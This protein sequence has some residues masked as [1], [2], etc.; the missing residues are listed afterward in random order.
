V[1]GERV[2]ESQQ[3]SEEV[4]NQTDVEDRPRLVCP[5]FLSFLVSTCDSLVIAKLGLKTGIRNLH[6]NWVTVWEGMC[7]VRIIV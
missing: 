1:H 7:T 5:A 3:G 6:L 2:R 4:S